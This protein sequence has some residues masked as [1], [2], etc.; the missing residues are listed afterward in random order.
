M[1]EDKGRVAILVFPFAAPSALI[2][3]NKMARTFSCITS[4]TVLVS[5]G[6]PD[7]VLW[8]DDVRIRDVGIRLHYLRQKQPTWLSA[9]LWIGKA[10]IAQ[11]KLAKEVFR[12]RNEVDT[13]VCFVGIHYQLPILMARLLGIKVICTSLGLLPL[14]A[15]LN[16]GRAAAIFTDFLS[17]FNFAL[18][19]AVLVDSLR[20]GTYEDLAP[21]RSKLHDGALFFEG[22]D[23]FRLQSAV[24]EREN[25]VGFIGRLTAEKGVMEFVQAI[26][27][28]LE[29][30]PDLRFLIIGA[31]TLDKELETAVLGQPWSSRVTWLGWVQ[32]EQIPEYLNRLKLV[33]V[34]TSEDGLPNR[35]LEAM[36]CGTPVLATSFGGIPDL[37]ID[38]K[39]GFLLRD[40]SPETIAE[41]IVRVVNDPCLEIITQRARALIERNY[42]QDAANERYQAIMSTVVWE[43]TYTG[44]QG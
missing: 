12:L 37:V 4:H 28:A 15:K 30:R 5:G 21:F 41:G 38:G 34:P 44:N 18:S 40:N 6:I 31:G 14:K 23:H 26:P 32:Y 11:S 27:L 42:S 19:Q 10:A 43:R 25:L 13:I 39:T 1:E 8:P 36:G 35:V 16:Y 3:A 20:L 17:R 29:R 33:V 9:M 22:F 7:N 24:D 2:L